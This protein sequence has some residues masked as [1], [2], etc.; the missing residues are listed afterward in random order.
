METE[1]HLYGDNACNIAWHDLIDK[2]VHQLVWRQREGVSYAHFHR[3]F[4]DSTLV[5]GEKIK[6]IVLLLGLIFEIT[7]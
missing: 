2:V 6:A 4:Y 1:V 3:Y 7:N 5:M